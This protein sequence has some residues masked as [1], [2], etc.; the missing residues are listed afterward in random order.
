L[1]VVRQRFADIK[2]TAERAMAQ[3]SDEEL[4]WSP[5]DESNSI[6]VIIK[7]MGGNM[8]SR[9]TEIF[10][11]DGE[12][13]D[14]NRDEEFESEGLNREALLALWDRGW[15]RLQDTLSGLT[16][17]DLLRTI[18][19]RSEPHSVVQAIERQMYHYGYHVG[20]IV[21]ICKLL[22]SSD[23]QTL[24]IPRRRG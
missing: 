17:E 22:R 15:T 5:N 7:H 3:V 8:L 19:I 2:R 4:F 14:R 21:Y 9:W 20:Q 24:T 12:K 6:A 10:E 13:P 16:E 18:V 1:A 11:T 23:W